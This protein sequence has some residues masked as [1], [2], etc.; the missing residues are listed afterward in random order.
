MFCSFG[1]RYIRMTEE[2]DDHGDQGERCGGHLREA[3]GQEVLPADLGVV[4]QAERGRALEA[5]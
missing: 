2:Q 5:P 1:E 3:E 4:R